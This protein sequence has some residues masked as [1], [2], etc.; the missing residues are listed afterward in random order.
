[1]MQGPGTHKRLFEHM[2]EEGLKNKLMTGLCFSMQLGKFVR[3]YSISNDPSGELDHA[4]TDCI[5]YQLH[6]HLMNQE[7]LWTNP[8]DAR[9]F[10]K[11]FGTF[12][13]LSCFVLT[14]TEK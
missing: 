7:Y 11:N 8:K 4:S 5:K 13:A 6:C 14:R 2:K 12:C 1:M 3:D 9:K 10:A